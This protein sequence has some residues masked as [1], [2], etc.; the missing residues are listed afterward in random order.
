M[1]MITTGSITRARK[2]KPLKRKIK[3]AIKY[4]LY[5]QT[6]N[7]AG[8]AEPVA[9]VAGL[10]GEAKQQKALKAAIWM[11]EKKGIFRADPFPLRETDLGI[12]LL[13]EEFPWALDRG[14]ISSAVWN[15]ASFT[16][17]DVMLD[18]PHHLSYPFVI[19]DDAGEAFIPEQSASDRV[20]LY[21]VQVT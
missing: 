17:G 11:T 10:E 8:I 1:D 4:R 6:W 21:R 5:R 20:V 12:E 14:L 9:V 15:G 7:V 16:P 3:D 13:F 18:L 2:R 19:A